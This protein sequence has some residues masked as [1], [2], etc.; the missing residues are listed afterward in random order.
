M[1]SWTA[2]L[3]HVS[4]RPGLAGTA[5]AQ[6][7]TLG[8]GP[9]VL[10]SWGAGGWWRRTV[11]GRPGT[12]PL[13]TEVGAQPE[14]PAATALFSSPTPQAQRSGKGRC[15]HPTPCPVVAAGWPWRAFPSPSPETG[16]PG[17]VDPA[18]A[19]EGPQAALLAEHCWGLGGTWEFLCSGLGA[20]TP[21]GTLTQRACPC[22]PRRSTSSQPG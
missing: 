16:A 17:E 20:W 7:P 3:E 15:P 14:L 2:T 22:T 1:P 12:D 6:P 19:P 9:A 13:C 10:W 8:D 21:G 11:P 4:A 5:V 18:G